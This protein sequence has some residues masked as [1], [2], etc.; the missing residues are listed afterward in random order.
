MKDV[1]EKIRKEIDN[2][3]FDAILVV[4][5]DN[6]QYFSGVVA[7]PFI[8]TYSEKPVV[9][10]WP[11]GDKPTFIVPSDWAETL[12]ETSRIKNIVTY[13]EE[14]HSF[15]RKISEIVDLAKKTQKIGI[16]TL[17][18]SVSLY[19][20]V[21]KQLKGYEFIPCDD[22]LR[23]LRIIKTPSEIKLL[24]KTAYAVDHGIFGQAHHV[25]ARNPRSELAL[26]EGIRVH[27]MERD[28][29]VIGWHSLSQ[30]VSGENATKYWPSAPF[31]SVGKGK[32]IAPRDYVRLEAKYSINGYWSDG[33]RLLTMGEPT[34]AQKE[35]YDL[36]VTI[37][38]K[39]VES[40][41]P[42][43]KC[44]EIYKVMSK[45][46]RDNAKTVEGIS[47]GHGVGVSDHEPPYI[48]ESDHTELVPGMVL[49]LEPT[50]IG[51]KGE[52]LFSKDTVVVTD[53][54]CRIIG[55]YKNWDNLYAAAHIN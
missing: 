20:D 32:E 16:D 2:S 55:W 43:K 52:I 7:A 54:G 13:N 27:C 46:I 30:G 31:Y 28:L 6:V 39:A 9:V 47:Y 3:E 21:K 34:N 12:Q 42:N 23:E 48:T 37:R 15:T 8:K 26:S 1:N 4:G 17:R 33:A 25:L 40:I 38:K 10:F 45:V 53:K 51:P 44:S 49:V 41:K 29:D 35:A 50:I 14:P 18:L 24:E 19:D 36:L 11:K 5:Q 22:F